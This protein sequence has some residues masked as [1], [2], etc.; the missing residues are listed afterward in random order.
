MPD[1][2][3]QG[4]AV[5]FLQQRHP[6]EPFPDL[7]QAL[8]VKLYFCII[9]LN[10]L[11]QFTDNRR[12]GGA[13]IFSIIER[14]I[15]FRQIFHLVPGFDKRVVNSLIPLVQ[16]LVQI[17][18]AS[19]SFSEFSKMRKFIFQFRFFSRVRVDVI[20]FFNLKIVEAAFFFQFMFLLQK[21]PHL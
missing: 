18:V 13:F 3:F 17:E 8:R 15:D 4:T 6:A 20:D 14:L 5:F 7:F 11:C 21:R 12:C 10:E 9:A 16:H 19:K 1:D 2:K